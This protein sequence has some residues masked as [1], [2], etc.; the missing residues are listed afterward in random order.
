[1]PRR[2]LIC[3]VAALA[4]L[5]APAAATAAP[6]MEV[7]I[8]D[9]RVLLDGTDA[10]VATAVA[11]W[12][13][14][15][16][17]V[18]RIQARWVAHVPTPLARRAPADFVAA[19]PSSPGYNWDRLDRAVAA[20]RGAGIR[21]ML[22]VTGS[23]PLWGTLDPSQ[24]NPRVRPSPAA[25]A[26]FATA[27]A[28]RYGALVDDYVLWNEPNHELWLQPQNVCTRGRCRPSAPHQYRALVRATGSAERMAGSAARTMIGALAPKGTSGRSRNARLRPLAFLRALGCVD[29]RYRRVRTG[30]CRGFRPAQGFG[31][32]YHPHGIT[33][34]PPVPAAHPDEAQLGDLSKLVSAIDRVTRA[35]GLRSRAPG[36]RFPIVLDE[37]GYETNPPDRRR[38]VSSARQ[39]TYLQQAA[40]LAWRHPRVRNLTNYVWQDE[41]MRAD[42][43]GW[44]SGLR[45]V[46]GRPKAALTSF[47][48]PFWAERRDT[49]TVRLWGQVRPEGSFT[50]TLQKRSASGSWQTLTRSGTDPRGYFTAGVR[51]RS[52]GTYRFRWSGGISSTRTVR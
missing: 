14:L 6:G 24:G 8:A 35:G 48:Q 5:G 37:H 52:R 45:T 30:D 20:V 13:A 39:S 4:C 7:G 29:G 28:R 49:R 10:E 44:Q 22:V 15:G 33:T 51:T 43:A 12:R 27:V 21:A 16:V 31:F 3:L 25:F 50:V 36:G 47:K 32:A 41:P 19:D 18:A 46:A 17:D 38:G 11:E 40:Y 26:G 23:G 1:M 9:D 2:L 42:G 34:A